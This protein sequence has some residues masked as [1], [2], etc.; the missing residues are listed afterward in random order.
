MA[1]GNTATFPVL[2][3]FL[4]DEVAS[5]VD[6]QNIIVEH[7]MKLIIEFD[8]YMPDNVFKYSWMRNPFKGNVGDLP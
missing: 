5:F 2:S 3:L 8:H 4:E 6:I 1:E 7:L